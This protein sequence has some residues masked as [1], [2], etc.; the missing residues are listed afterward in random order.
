MIETLSSPF[1]FFFM[2][3]AFIAVLLLAIPTSLL[4]CFLVLK[5]WSLMGDA[6]SHA[7]LPG[8][9]LAYIIGFPFS[10]GAFLAGIFCALLTGYLNE[11]S[12]VKEDTIMG[13]VF[14]GMFA[15]G[16]ILHTKIHSDIHLLHI[17][18]GNMLGLSW[19]DILETAI[20]CALV[21]ISITFFWRDLTLSV[22]DPQHA[23]VIGIPARMVHYGILIA[24]ALTIVGALKAI[25][26][27][28]TIAMLIAPGAIAF[29]FTK[30]IKRMMLVSLLVGL[31]SS[32][33]GVYL[34]FFFDSAPAPT[35]VLTMTIIFIV[36]F[37]K[38]NIKRH[39]K[40][41]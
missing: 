6:V 17:L 21:V 15:V 10:L 23:H 34:S 26:I 35:I 11:N 32:F 13:V 16:I 14:S 9:V 24:L 41:V 4:S 27:I 28:L 22:F 12:R 8:I 5:G 1:Q 37:C 39:S 36:G 33:V 2:Q 18:F 7:V 38:T 30:Q 20:I 29:L 3:Q 19:V 31:G 25:G 40:G